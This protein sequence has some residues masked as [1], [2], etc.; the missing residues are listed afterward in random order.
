MIN[1]IVMFRFGDDKEQAKIVKQ[2]LETLPSVISEIKHYEIGINM[3]ESD[4]AYDMVLISKFDSMDDLENYATH[5][6]HEEV[7]QY[8]RSVASSIVAV[9]YES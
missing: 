9:D 8:I 1:H 7:L 6:A 4:R 3:I 2:K 5:P